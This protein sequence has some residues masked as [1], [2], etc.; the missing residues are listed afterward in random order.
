ME[1]GLV[2]SINTYNFVYM[3]YTKYHRYLFKGRQHDKPIMS[4][5]VYL[6]RITHLNNNCLMDVLLPKEPCGSFLRR[7][8]M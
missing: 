2:H 6:V 1:C 5:N 8:H 4:H 7:I 3:P